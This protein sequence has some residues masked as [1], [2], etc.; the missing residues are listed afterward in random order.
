MIT[1][2]D[3]ANKIVEIIQKD[4][5]DGLRETHGK[6]RSPRIDFFN[7]RVGVPLG[8]PYCAS[9]GWSAIEDACQA[10]GLK[11]PVMPT[12][13]SQAFRRENFVPKQYLRPAGSLGRKGDVGVFQSSTT[14]YLGH[15]TVLSEDQVEQPYFNTLEYNTDGSGS[16]DGDGAYAMTRS[17]EGVYGNKFFVCFTDV[18][19]WIL[20]SNLFPVS[21]LQLA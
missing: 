21:C 14:S 3:I 11:N 19:Q 9:A 15:Y 13:S 18:P 17:T 10:L 12:G 16:R 4:V 20:D 7:K 8:S 6:N 2:E 5:S 1:R